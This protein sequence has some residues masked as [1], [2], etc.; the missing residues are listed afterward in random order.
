M[1]VDE[2]TIYIE[3]GKGGNGCVSFRREKY[4]PNGGPDGGDGGKGGDVVFVT[5]ENLNTLYDFRGKRKYAAKNGM[6]GSSR[7]R[8]G[9]KG[10]DLILHV[11]VGTVIKEAKSGLVI[12]DMSAPNMRETLLTGGKG[13]K[14]NQHYA[15]PTMQIPK[16]AQPGQEGKGLSV[17]LELKVLADVGLLGCP[18]A[19]KS[20]FLAAVSNARPRIADYPFTTLV[21]Q[22]GL[23]RLSYGKTLVVADIPG[24]VEG[25]ADGAGLGHEFL[26]HLERTRVLIHLVDA[27]GVDGRDPVEDLIRINREL[28]L[29]SPK[30]AAL[31]QVVGANKMDLPDSAL[32]YEALTKYCEEQNVPLFPI[33]AATGQGVRELLDA[34]VAIRD[35]L[36]ED[37]PAVFEPEFFTE[38]SVPR[39]AEE[40]GGIEVMIDPDGVYHIAGRPI[41][42]MLGYTNLESERGFAFFQKFLRERGVIDRLIEMQIQEGDTIEVGGIQ[43]EYYA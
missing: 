21:P 18:N 8:F 14:G 41:D 5:D 13:G 32:F 3:S 15:T 40:D 28:A 16:Y 20:T 4:V 11:P 19:G 12:K 10:E 7:N 38:D 43:F 25:A 23:V 17:K 22:L 6:D 27:A 29:Y 42:K 31:P 33:S 30:L 9:L 1:F 2:V 26:R 34:V 24:L 37:T 35:Q 36:R 39:G